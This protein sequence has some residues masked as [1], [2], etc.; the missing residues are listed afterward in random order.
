[1]TNAPLIRVCQLLN[2]SGARYLV[3]GGQACILH[4][5]VRTTEDVDI[6]IEAT[7]ENCTA[8]IAGLSRMEDG[9]ASELT[10]RDLLENFVVKIADEVEVDVST[11]A[12]KVT[13]PEALPGA[14]N[15]E[16]NGVSIPFIGLDGLIASK[17][18]SREQGA[19]DRQ[20]L[21]ALKSRQR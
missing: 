10:A 19:L 2:E 17:E 11:H 13:Y 16:I 14:L 12:W 4:G 1:M 20:R 15:V 5:L 9:A 3:I 8:V 21:M 7:E 6:L 18:T